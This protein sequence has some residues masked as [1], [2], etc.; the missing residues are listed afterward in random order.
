[1]FP[2]SSAGLLSSPAGQRAERVGGKRP[3]ARQKPTLGKF[4]W[5][6]SQREEGPEGLPLGG[7]RAARAGGQRASPPVPA[8][9]TPQA[10][11]PPP[12]LCP[13][14]GGLPS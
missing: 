7:S 6:F 5:A 4:T 8:P 10:W 9:S 12:V 2:A 13:W 11:S 3:P 1:M 14:V